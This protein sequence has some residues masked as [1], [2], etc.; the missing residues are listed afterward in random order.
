ML[1]PKLEQV[2]LSSSIA[3]KEMLK[4][5]LSLVLTIPMGF[6]FDDLDVPPSS[7]RS[8]KFF[9]CEFDYIG[10]SLIL[11]YPFFRNHLWL[12]TDD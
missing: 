11:S 9:C 8:G 1:H 3:Y 10:F 2:R 5:K 6:D 4:S 7:I 12:S